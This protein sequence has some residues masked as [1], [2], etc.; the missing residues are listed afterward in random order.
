[1][2]RLAPT[3][4]TLKRLFSISGNQCA[5][6]DCSN[7]LVRENNDL[8]A[9]ICHIEAA[10]PGGERYNTMQSD[11]QR[12]DISNLIILCPTHHR[13]TNNVDEFP[14]LA[15]QEMKRRHEDKYRNSRYTPPKQVIEVASR[16]IEIQADVSAVN[17]GGLQIVNLVQR[18]ES[19][20][21]GAKALAKDLAIL[22]IHQVYAKG[23][24]QSMSVRQQDLIR[25][26]AFELLKVHGLSEEDIHEV[27]AIEFPYVCNEYVIY[28]FQAVNERNKDVPGNVMLNLRQKLNQVFTSRLEPDKLREL[29]KQNPKFIEEPDVKLLLEDYDYYYQNQ[30]HRHLERWSRRESW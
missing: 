29:F 7:S 27:V 26:H 14:V 1:M 5:F 9:D 23:G 21:Q 4:N 20:F 13:V 2:T 6:P 17:I 22:F 12:R 15:M 10:E 11:E 16:Q 18:A 8:V 19:A 25:N 3:P 28:V 24:F 30:K